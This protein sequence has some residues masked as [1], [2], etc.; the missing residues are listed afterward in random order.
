MITIITDKRHVSTEC[1]NEQRLKLLNSFLALLLFN[2]SIIMCMS[3][4]KERE[5]KITRRGRV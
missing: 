1:K 5:I 4:P 2:Y 3:E